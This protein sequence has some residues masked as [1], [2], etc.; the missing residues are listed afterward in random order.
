[1]M[2]PARNMSW[3]RSDDSSSGPMVGRLSTTATI[4]PPDTNSGNTHATV[5]TI[6]LIATRTGYLNS[7]RVSSTPLARAVITYCLRSSSSRVARMMR[8]RPAMPPRPITSTGTGRCPSMSR[9][10]ATDQSAFR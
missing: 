2:A 9:T 3:P 7:S 10:R 1:M 8:C 4:A 5:L 6:G